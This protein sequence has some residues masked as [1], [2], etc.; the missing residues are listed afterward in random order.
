MSYTISAKKVDIKLVQQKD[1]NGMSPLLQTFFLSR[2][3]FRLSRKHDLHSL[4]LLMHT[5]IFFPNVQS[6]RLHF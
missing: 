1:R 5:K 4:L 3:T 6:F 2:I